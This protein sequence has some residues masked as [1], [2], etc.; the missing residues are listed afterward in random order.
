VA[1]ARSNLGSLLNILGRQKSES[2][3]LLKHAIAVLESRLTPAHPQ[4][5]LARENLRKAQ[6]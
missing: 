1:L 6:S 4:L 5:L 2:V 3:P